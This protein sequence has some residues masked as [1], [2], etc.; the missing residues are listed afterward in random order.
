MRNVKKSPVVIL[1]IVA[2]V[3]YVI[4]Y[5][6]PQVTGV[7]RSSYTAEY[8]ELKTFDKVE[9]YFVRSEYVYFSDLTGTANRYID[10]NKL[11]RK[12]TRI[13]EVKAGSAA[14]DDEA[15][16]GDTE[17][18]ASEKDQKKAG[19]GGAE[20]KDKASGKEQASSGDDDGA[21][22]TEETEDTGKN[23]DVKALD[24]SNKG[25]AQYSEIRKNVKGK[26]KITTSD[27]VTAQEGILTYHA[28]G[29]ES[30]ITPENMEKKDKAF[31]Q[32]LKNSSD[33]ELDNDIIA[34]T[35]PVF[36]IVDRAEWYIVC[37]IPREHESR[38]AVGSS[39][40]VLINDE[41]TITGTVQS[42]TD[43]R[44]AKRLTIKTNNWYE[45]FAT[46]RRADIEVITSDVMGLIISNTSIVER[47]GQKGVYVRQKTGKYKFVPINI[48][49]TD[50]TDSAISPS[51]YRNAEGD[52]VT[53]VRS[54]D[55]ILR[56]PDRK[57][58]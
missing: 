40:R 29:N 42:I 2:A 51:Q 6:L 20:G 31:F 38:Y 54:Y 53:T 5:I 8:G 28:D 26:H 39:V 17:A 16:A 18:E 21:E 32:K 50:G 13:M 34:V 22:Q 30:R 7:L 43:E 12:G 3:L 57:A 55:D 1:F 23:E 27:F 45:H 9:G 24:T 4:I 36:K 37:Y 41:K 19:S 47:K 10:E 11:V 44:R 33:L 46:L 56:R 35:D 15:G 48:I 49:A 25:L 14:S 58:S 52:T